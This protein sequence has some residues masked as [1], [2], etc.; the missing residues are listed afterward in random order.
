VVTRS[1][2]ELLFFGTVGEEGPDLDPFVLLPRQG[3]RW[4]RVTIHRGD[5]KLEGVY[6]LGDVLNVQIQQIDV[7]S[8]NWTGPTVTYHSTDGGRSWTVSKRGEP[9]GN[10]VTA[11][12]RTSQEWQLKFEQEGGYIVEKRGNEGYRAVSHFPAPTACE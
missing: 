7:H 3:G 11:I 4:K 9:L 5:S 12:S 10:P 8:D 2:K 1:G 6:R